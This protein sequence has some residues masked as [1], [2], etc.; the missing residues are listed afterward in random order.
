MPS[1]QKQLANAMEL[2]RL[3]LQLARDPRSKVFLP[4]AEEYCKS[5]MWQ[6]A[7]AVLE[8]GLKY[9]PGFVTAMVVLGR[10]YDQ[11]GQPAK[12]KTV[13]EE[14]VKVSPDNLR[15]HR[16]LLKIYLAQGLMDEARKSCNVILSLNSRDEEALTVQV[17]LEQFARSSG[18]SPAMAVPPSLTTPESGDRKHASSPA[19]SHADTI[20]KLESWLRSIERERQ[21]R[22]APGKPDSSSSE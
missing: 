7:A 4:L 21:D 16:I 6:E 20:E 9:Y 19:D 22:R 11:I 17:K 10:A 14:A 12:A 8:D 5:G 2:D 1:H 18:N 3:A 15:A 13:L